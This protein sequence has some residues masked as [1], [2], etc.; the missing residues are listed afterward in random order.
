VYL[1][2]FTDDLVADS[3]KLPDD[4]QV[5][6]DPNADAY[7]AVDL[8]A[9]SVRTS[10]TFV[11]DCSGYEKDNQPTSDIAKL[12]TA[13]YKL[14]VHEATTGKVLGSKDLAASDTEC[15]SFVTFDSDSSTKDYYDSPSTDE[16]VAFVKPFAQP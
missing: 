9:C 16:V 2:T 15:P 14:T 3:F 5:K 12:H 4:W 7:A 1:E 10:D 8:V 13:T 6:F 11:K